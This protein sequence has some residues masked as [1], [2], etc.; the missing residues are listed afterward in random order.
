MARPEESTQPIVLLFE[1]IHPEAMALLRAQAHVRLAQNLDEAALV[2]Q[3]AD[4]DGIV[5]RA[6]DVSPAG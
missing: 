2:A 4:V 6:K 3:V 1:P 5:I